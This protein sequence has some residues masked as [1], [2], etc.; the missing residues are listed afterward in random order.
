MASSRIARF[1]TEVAPPQ[2]MSVMRNRT[3]KILDTINE[4]DREISANDSH[5]VI[6]TSSSSGSSS[7]ASPNKKLPSCL[8]KKFQRAFALFAPRHPDLSEY[9]FEQ[10]D[11]LVKAIFHF[12]DGT[13]R[14]WPEP[15]ERVYHHPMGG[16][17]AIPLEHL[18]SMRPN[19]HQFTKSLCRDVYGI[20]FTQL[21]PN[22]VK[23]VSWFLSCCHVKKY[24]PTF[25]L[26]HYLFK[27]KKSTLPTLFEFTFN[28]DGCGFPADAKSAPIFMLNSLR[29]W[30]QEFIFVWGGDL[31]FMPV[32]KTALKNNRFPTERLSGDA[33]AKIY[34][35]VVALG[36]Q[37]TRDTFLD[38]QTLYNS[39][40]V[41][42]TPII[43]NP[44]EVEVLE[45]DEEEV[46]ALNLRKR[47]ATEDA[48]GGS[49]TPQR[50]R[51]SASGPSEEE[52]QK[53]VEEDVLKSLLARMT[54]DDRRNE[55][56]DNYASPADFE[57]Y[58]KEDLDTF[59]DHLVWDISEELAGEKE[60]FTKYREV[61]EKESR[62]HKQ[63]V[64]E[65]VK[66]REAA[67]QM[68]GSLRAEVEN[69]KKEFASRPREEEVLES[70]RGT[71]DY[72]EELNNKIFE[73]VNICWDIASAY[74]AENPGGDMD[75]FIELYLAEELRREEAKT[76]GEGT[77][78][79][80]PPPP[81]EEVRE[82]TPPPPEN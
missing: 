5:N 74:L 60:R 34:D 48:G 79:T 9:S 43:P 33:L 64:T 58:A 3:S 70:F 50:R 73:K 22:F 26:F 2:I 57:C 37:W 65:A 1:A 42:T 28:I 21:A 17:V 78:R 14:R 31:E 71:P 46:G 53:L 39:V 63:A 4:D 75:G 72:Y 6:P 13:E 38:N 12:G 44:E 67:E 52:S 8:T 82:K 24:L 7:A 62:E 15:H 61:K 35:F 19:L 16:W 47:K 11:D 23:W 36:A 80:Q 30:H 54:L 29:G 20:P 55:M 81:A 49:G 68:V 25:K 32:Y 56:F 69:L 45:L 41:V 59:L 27:I 10:I 66:A 76:V 40:L 77:S 51:L 18:R